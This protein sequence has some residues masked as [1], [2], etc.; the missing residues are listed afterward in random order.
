MARYT[1]VIDKGWKKALDDLKEFFDEN[2]IV[3]GVVDGQEKHNAGDDFT[4]AQLAAVHEF[5]SRNG[6]IPQRSFIRST[7]DESQAKIIAAVLKAAKL[8]SLGSISDDSAK[9]QLGLLGEKLIKQKIRSNIPPK[10]SP[11]TIARKKAKPSNS[12]FGG[13]I[14]LID[15]GRLINSIR[16]KIRQKGT[17]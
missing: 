11:E 12:K 4:M 10:L 16:Y 7:F 15:T 13:T 6:R 17:L 3:V 14:A 1:R 5:G 2:E 9:K 8:V